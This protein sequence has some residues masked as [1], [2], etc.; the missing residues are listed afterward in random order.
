ML[1]GPLANVRKSQADGTW[2]VPATFES[3]ADGTWKVPA[4]FESQ[5][6]GTWKVPATFER[7]CHCQRAKWAFA[8]A[9]STRKL[10]GLNSSAT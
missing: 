8:Q 7:E 1:R 6:D 4:T 3:Q 5:A 10:G 2:K 9:A